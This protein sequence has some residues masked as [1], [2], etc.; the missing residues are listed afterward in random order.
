MQWECWPAIDGRKEDSR[1]REE[2]VQKPEGTKV[3]EH[4]NNSLSLKS[5]HGG[6]RN[7]QRGWR[8]RCGLDHKVPYMSQ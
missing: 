2:Y 6:F 8:E 1:Q 4:L 5:T 7:D 3:I